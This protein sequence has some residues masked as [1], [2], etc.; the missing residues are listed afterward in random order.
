MLPADKG[1]ALWIEW[2]DGPVHRM[3]IDM[4]TGNAGRALRKRLEALPAADRQ[5]ELLVVT[6]VDEDHIGG[7]LSAVVDAAP[8]PGLGFT[9]VWFNGWKHLLQAGVDEYGAPHGERLTQ[10]LGSQPWNQAFGGAAV[11]LDAPLLRAALAD[12]LTLTVLGP[13]AQRLADFRGRW[14][15]DVQLAIAKGRLDAAEVAAGIQGFEVEEYGGPLVLED[16]MDLRALAQRATPLDDSQANGSSICLLLEYRGIRILLTG[17]AFGGDIVAGL[18]AFGPTPARFSAV[19]L[20]HHAAHGN[21]TAELV[22][23]LDCQDWLI[24]TNGAQHGHPHPS[25]IA[26]I[27][28]A[29]TA[30]TRLHFNVRSQ[31]NAIWDRADWGERFAYTPRYGD[32]DGLQ[33]SWDDQGKSN[34]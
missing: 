31:V 25:A 7:V 32:A 24:S 4:G 33:L 14:A 28:D 19:K 20:P 21:V 34:H 3:L 26:R 22:A 27:L 30:P 23:A 13:P 2:G 18:K 15:E 29:A 10:W 1:D 5:F 9:D 8:L 16:R 6:H 17:D 12:G 11:R